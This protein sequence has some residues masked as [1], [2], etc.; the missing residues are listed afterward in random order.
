MFLSIRLNLGFR[1]QEYTASVFLSRT[2]GQAHCFIFDFFNVVISGV[3]SQIKEL[4][5]KQLLNPGRE[6]EPVTG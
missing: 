2:L 5:I 4:Q 6:F 1:V 3:Q